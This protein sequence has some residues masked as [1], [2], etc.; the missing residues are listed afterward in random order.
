MLPPKTTVPFFLSNRTPAFRQGARFP[1]I[2]T[3]L[4]RPP[5]IW[6]WPRRNVPAKGMAVLNN[7]VLQF[8]V[9]DNNCM[10]WSLDHF[11]KT[12]LQQEEQMDCHQVW[13]GRDRTHGRPTPTPS[14]TPV[15]LRGPVRGWAE[16]RQALGSHC[17]GIA[18]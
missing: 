14:P 5:C 10:A 7:C 9:A 8:L 18:T 12:P 1:K 15:S 13:A 4:P 11:A 6:P 16:R 17:P 2:K 3:T